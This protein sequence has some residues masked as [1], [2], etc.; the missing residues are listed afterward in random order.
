MEYKIYPNYPTNFG[1]LFGK[2]KM[3]FRV[4]NLMYVF[5]KIYNSDKSILVVSIRILFLYWR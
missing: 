4:Y 5:A 1:I 2:S 3:P